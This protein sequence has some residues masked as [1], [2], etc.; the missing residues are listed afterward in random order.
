[1]LPGAYAGFTVSTAVTILGAGS[2]LVQTGPVVVTGVP[3][4]SVALLSGMNLRSVFFEF[5]PIFPPL[6]VS[7]NNGTVVAHDLVL[8]TRATVL[9]I[10]P[11]REIAARANE[12]YELDALAQQALK[13]KDNE[14][15]LTKGV[16]T[17]NRF[18]S[19][20][21]ETAEWETGLVDTYGE[22]DRRVKQ[23]MAERD[24][25][26]RVIGKYKGLRQE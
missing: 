2:A 11:A 21:E 6:E 26:F 16:E 13:K 18:N 22:D 3:D 7:G 24:K 15:Y 14:T 1:M 5:P 12:A 20:L 23:I 10:D 8:E 17:R 4:G 9:G 19:L 25:W